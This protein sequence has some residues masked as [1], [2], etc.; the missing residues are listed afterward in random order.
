MLWEAKLRSKIIVGSGTFLEWAMAAWHEADPEL[1]L[2]AINITQ[3]SSYRFDLSTLEGIE[4]NSDTTAFAACNEQ[5]LNFRRFELMGE[6]K[7]RGFAMPALICPGALV[8]NT[9]QIGQ[10]SVIGAGA[11]IGHGCQIGFNTVI[12]AGANIGSQ[13]RIG[14]SN[15]IESGVIIGSNAKTGA[16]ATIGHGVM[17][18]NKVE[19]GKLCIVD[20]PGKIVANIPAKTFIH[21]SFDTPIITVDYGAPTITTSA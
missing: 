7:A 12:G 3:D 5:F 17:I 4:A 14:T 13:T 16:N 18:G 15:W 9:A 21:N 6:L 20:K 11:I 19:I 8:A 2:T 10:N 1:K